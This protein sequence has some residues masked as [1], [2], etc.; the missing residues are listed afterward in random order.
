MSILQ[1]AEPRFF[2]HRSV[3]A[4]APSGGVVVSTMDGL[5]C[6]TFRELRV[7]WKNRTSG[8]PWFSKM[9]ETEFV[10]F[11]KH[12]RCFCLGISRALSIR[13]RRLLR[14]MKWLDRPGR[15]KFCVRT[16]CVSRVRA[17]A[18]LRSSTT[19]LDSQNRP[20]Y[21][22]PDYTCSSLLSPCSKSLLDGRLC[23]CK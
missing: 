8:S 9:K 20:T 10:L 14:S 23:A 1:L 17:S 3:E 4:A 22:S 18:C 16:W 2:N 6:H 21:P 15:A 7:E 13:L 5:R 11:P 12:R 19:N